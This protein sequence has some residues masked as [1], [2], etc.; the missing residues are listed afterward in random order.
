MKLL[1]DSCVWSGAVGVLQD[2]GHDAIWAGSWQHDPGDKAIL[3]QA[4]HEHRVLVTLDK[5]FGELAIVQGLPHAGI[6]R[7]VNQS[8]TQQAALTLLVIERYQDELARAAIITVE[9]ERV[10]IRLPDEP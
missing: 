1:V 5:D 3:A 8:A 6:I 10:R 9:P 2:A 4:F 7:L